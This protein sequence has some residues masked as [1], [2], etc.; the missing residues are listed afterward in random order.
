MW[1]IEYVVAVSMYACGAAHDCYVIATGFG[2]EASLGRQGQDDR[3]GR[4]S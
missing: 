1:Q 2:V 3:L 4:R